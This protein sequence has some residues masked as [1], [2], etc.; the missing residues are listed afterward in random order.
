MQVRI[1]RQTGQLETVVEFYRDALGLPEIDRFTDHGGY[2]HLA[3]RRQDG[4]VGRGASP[5]P[6]SQRA[7]AWRQRAAARN[8]PPGR[9]DRWHNAPASGARR[10]VVFGHARSIGGSAA[11]ARPLGHGFGD[12]G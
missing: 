4:L 3:P 5:E 7:I 1:A 2:G 11:A 10:Q 6:E 9:R 8:Q 12:P